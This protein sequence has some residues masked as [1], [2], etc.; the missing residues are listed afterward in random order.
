MLTKEASHEVQRVFGIWYVLPEAWYM[1]L[2][3]VLCTRYQV[4]KR[5]P[6]TNNLP[7]PT[8]EI[9]LRSSVFRQHFD[10]CLRHGIWDCTKYYVPGTKY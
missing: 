9:K 2:Y 10:V 4:L 1:G 8:P 7:S 6:S 5:P 3:Q